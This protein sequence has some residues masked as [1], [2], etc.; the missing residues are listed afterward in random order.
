MTRHVGLPE[1]RFRSLPSPA[2]AFGVF[3]G[4]HRGHQAVLREVVARARALG[5]AAVAVTFDRHPQAVLRGAPVPAITSLEHRL[6]LLERAGAGLALALPFTLDLAPISPEQFLDRFFRDEIPARALVLGFD[7]RFGRD[8]AGDFARAK[9]WGG[10][11]GVEVVRA[12]EVDLG[13]AKVSS[14]AVRM[15]V[16]GG[17]LDDAEAML[18]RPP[19]LYG[20]VV[21]GD[22]RGRRLG[23]P[24]ANLDLH[25]ELLPP[26]GVYLAKTEIGGR[27]YRAVVNIGVRPTFGGGKAEIVEAHVLDFEGDLYGREVE[28][29]FV[30]KLRDERRFDSP[31]ALRAQIA[32]DVEEVRKG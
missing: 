27:V 26:R 2:C 4:V 10:A 14:S 19:S 31:E 28:L 16:A 22:G 9:A 24:T 6:V 1:G 29:A 18:G 30:K 15:A 20:T 32:A 3:D 23:F 12:P 7:Q 8:A 21:R 25:H 13:G 11:R 17:R 5:G